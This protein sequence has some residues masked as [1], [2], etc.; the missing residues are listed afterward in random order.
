MEAG[1][2]QAGALQALLRSYGFSSTE[3]RLDLAGIG[4]LVAGRRSV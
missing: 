4:R 2:G 1:Q 3:V